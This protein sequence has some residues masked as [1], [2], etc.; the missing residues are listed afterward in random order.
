MWRWM[1]ELQGHRG[2]WTR[3]EAQMRGLS[4]HNSIAC[5]LHTSRL[6]QRSCSPALFTRTWQEHRCSRRW[7]YQQ[8]PYW[9]QSSTKT[10]HTNTIRSSSFQ[11]DV[12]CSLC[13]GW[14]I[15]MSHR[16]NCPLF[17]LPWLAEEC[18]MNSCGGTAA[19]WFGAVLVFYEKQCLRWRWRET[20]LT[21]QQKSVHVLKTWAS[22][23]IRHI[24]GLIGRH[25]QIKYS[26]A[27]FSE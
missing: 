10:W 7:S 20:Q 22:G 5:L 17:W 13:F 3:A 14:C 11:R 2:V 24:R 23:K 27:S 12:A 1:F 18:L 9:M 4:S 16:Q 8:Q 19:C 26:S 25:W 6:S 21:S 15:K